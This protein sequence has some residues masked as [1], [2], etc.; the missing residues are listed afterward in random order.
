MYRIMIARGVFGGLVFYLMSEES[1]LTCSRWEPEIFVHPEKESL[2]RY[3]CAS[4]Y[5][6]PSGEGMEVQV[7]SFSKPLAGSEWIGR[8][9]SS[10]K[11]AWRAAAAYAG[12][13]AK[14]GEIEEE[15]EW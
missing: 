2:W 8:E 1:S 7:K 11:S 3:T 9:Y 10:E 4:K 13:L 6:H 14:R 5:Y 15:Y 12:I